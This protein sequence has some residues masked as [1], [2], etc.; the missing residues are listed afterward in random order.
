M[1]LHEIII[2]FIIGVVAGL[3]NIMAGGGSMLT[4][5]ALIFL[6]LDGAAANGTNRI[7]IL[8]Q[9]IFAVQSFH[10]QR[11]FPFKES[12]RISLWTLPGAIIG[13]F[14]A[15]KIS[16]EWFTRI[17]AVVMIG[18]VC[19]LFI[20]PP[21]RRETAPQDKP[22]AIWINVTM[23]ALGFYGGFIQVGIGFLFIAALYHLEKL[24]LIEV[25]MY[26]V[27]ITF[28]YTIP[29]LIIFMRTDNVV[30]L[31]G[32]VLAAG[33]AVGGWWS[34]RLAIKKGEKLIRIVLIVAVGLMSIKL[35]GIF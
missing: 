13:A 25:N 15:T 16:T 34:A 18:V 24:D 31:P 8:V 10:Q 6:G 32:L 35:V 1:Q 28:V 22:A 20:K 33:T 2:L 21:D 30:W 27:F 26:K 5:P 7:A 3:V 19:T 17:L 4:V 12:L 23:L 11:G 14:F 9:N 29:A